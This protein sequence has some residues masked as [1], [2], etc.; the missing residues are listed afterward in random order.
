MNTKKITIPY[1]INFEIKIKIK[2][3][4]NQEKFQIILLFSLKIKT[5][6]QSKK[7]KE[8]FLFKK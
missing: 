6:K 3:L 5:L 7:N 2:N 8:L 4:F 1:G